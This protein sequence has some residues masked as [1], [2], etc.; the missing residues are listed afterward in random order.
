MDLKS[1]KRY[2]FPS[3]VSLF[4][5]TGCG[6]GSDGESNLNT[7]DN[8]SSSSTTTYATAQLGNLANATVKIYVVED[9]G[10]LTLKWSEQTSSGDTLDEI[11]KFDLHTQD[12]DPDRFYLYKVNGGEDWDADDDGIRD[13]N[14]TINDG[15]IR[16]IAKGNDIIEIGSKFRVTLASEILY[17]FVAKTL[18]YEFN[19]T[20]FQDTLKEMAAKIVTDIDGNGVVDI[21]DIVLFNPVE[22]KNY[23]KTLFKA[24]W[25]EWILLVH[26]GKIPALH[27]SPILG[28]V[29]TPGSAM[30]ITLSSDGATA[31]V[32]DG[33]SGLQ[34]IDISDPT[35]P[36]IKGSVDTPGFAYSVKLS[37]DGTLAYVADGEGGLQIIDVSDPDNP[38]IIGNIDTPGSAWDVELSPDKGIAFIADYQAGLQIVDVH[39]PTALTILGNFDT[40]KEALGIVLSSDGSTAYMTTW[41][42]DIL[43]LDVR[44]HAN[45]IIIGSVATAVSGRNITLSSD[46]TW[47]YVSDGFGGLEIVDISEP[48]NPTIVSIIDTPD[49]AGIAIPFGNI[50]YIADGRGGIQIVDVSDPINPIII[51]NIDTPGSAKSVILSSDGTIAYVA[52]GDRGIQIIDLSLLQ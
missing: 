45:P 13:E 41:Y 9:N 14:A 39:D 52:D 1:F 38:T 37:L 49:Y 28:S 10:S 7:N 40:T 3:L 48:S 34:I 27:F 42:G 4:L 32:V 21:K 33:D 31:Y 12:L 20:T 19:V 46:E 22:H 2:L 47:A 29:D 8:T 35:K 50:V 25:E 17:E 44:D 11:G 30:G 15:V 16:A 36:T 6:G 5:L 24:K 23:L 51:R 43:V 18:K 26:E